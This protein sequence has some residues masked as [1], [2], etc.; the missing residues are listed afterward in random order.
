LKKQADDINKDI[1]ESYYRYIGSSHIES[2][3]DALEKDQD[4]IDEVEIS[5]EKEKWFKNYISDLKKKEKK[6]RRRKLFKKYSM[7]AATF[8]IVV[9]LSVS[10]LTV[11]VEGFRV[12]LFNFLVEKNKKFTSVIIEE[13]DNAEI[14]NISDWD[15]YYPSYLPE[16]YQ[17]ETKDVF[18]E[19]RILK[20]ANESNE[21]FFGQGPNGTDF[22]LDTEGGKRSEVLVNDEKSILVEK[23]DQNI[24]LWNKMDSSFYIVSD[25]D[26]NELLKIANNIK[27]WNK[28]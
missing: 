22:H 10:F 8:L 14:I 24:L 1:L 27:R 5:E 23:N 6:I 11:S 19:I 3:I 28:F 18:N 15:H 4:L 26:V 25:I 16:G 7:R 12:K 17:L 9:F 13:D 21:M 20:F 2:I